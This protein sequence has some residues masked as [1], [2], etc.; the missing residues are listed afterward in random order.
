MLGDTWEWNGA[1]WS[2][3]GQTGPDARS[4]ASAAWDS[5]FEQVVLF[6]GWD[7]SAALDDLWAWDGSG[8]MIGAPADGPPGQRANFGMI[9]DTGHGG[10][11]VVLFG[12]GTDNVGN[13]LYGDTWLLQSDSW[14]TPSLVAAPAARA[15]FG[16]AYDSA[17]NVGVLFGG[18][19]AASTYLGDTWAWN[20]DW[21]TL[22][23]TGSPT[24]RWRGGLVFDSGRGVTVL[25]GGAAP[26]N[27]YFAETWEL[28][29]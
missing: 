26:P 3:T 1:T 7:G 28:A 8:W 19:G 2:D 23:T 21:A 5:G 24:A 27:T 25:F 29:W 11:Q 15:G 9:Y 14:V 17:R 16:F 22:P 18:L 20:G 13:G 12:G 6:G 10:G 4:F